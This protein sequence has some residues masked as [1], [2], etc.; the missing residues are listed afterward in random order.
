MMIRGFL[1][2]AEDKRVMRQPR[3][4]DLSNV[5]SHGY[6]T[7]LLVLEEH[8]CVDSWYVEDAIA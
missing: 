2:D 8:C 7:S 1:Q 4:Y 5:L 6:L 3:P